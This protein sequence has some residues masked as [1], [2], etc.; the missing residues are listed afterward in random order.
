[1]IKVGRVR[2]KIREIM[3]PAYLTIQ[4]QN[5]YYIK[6]FNMLYPSFDNSSFLNSNGDADQSSMANS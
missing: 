2:F 1:L 4:E 3:S 6:K 5:E